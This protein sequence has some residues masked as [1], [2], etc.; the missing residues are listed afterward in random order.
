LDLEKKGSIWDQLGI[1]EIQN[2]R[3]QEVKVDLFKYKEIE[4]SRVVYMEKTRE[5]NQTWDIITKRL[6]EKTIENTESVK[7]NNRKELMDYM[8]LLLKDK[9]DWVKTKLLDKLSNNSEFVDHIIKQKKP[10]RI[11]SFVIDPTFYYK[12]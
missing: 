3:I 12:K 8:E 7:F 5:I 1:S 11:D 10:E 4:E 2:N 6:I 9:D